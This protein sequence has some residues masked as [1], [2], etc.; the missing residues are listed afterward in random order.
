M[1]VF[2][3]SISNSPKKA[4]AQRGFAIAAKLDPITTSYPENSRVIRWK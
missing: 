3:S 1:I 4:L 2:Q